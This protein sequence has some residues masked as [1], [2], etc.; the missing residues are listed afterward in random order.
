VVTRL[1]NGVWWFTRGDTDDEEADDVR[2]VSR[3]MTGEL[4]AQR[5]VTGT[6]TGGEIQRR[7]A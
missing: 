1:W 5:R 7:R 3:P 6:G 2:E 4:A